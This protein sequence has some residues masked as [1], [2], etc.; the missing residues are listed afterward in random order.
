[1]R[2]LLLLLLLFATTTIHGQPDPAADRQPN[3][4]L[5]HP[6]TPLYPDTPL[7]QGAQHLTLHTPRNAIV[8]VH[9][10]KDNGLDDAGISS[11]FAHGPSDPDTPL[12]FDRFY[13]Q[14]VPVEQNTGL[15]SRTER[16]ERRD[17]PHVL[18]GAPFNVYEVMRDALG[19]G[20]VQDGRLV[21][22]Y[23]FHIPADLSTG[24]YEVRVCEGDVGLQAPLR[25]SL[26]VH[27]AVLPDPGRDT[28]GFTNWINVNTIVRFHGVSWFGEDFWPVLDRYAALCAEMRQNVIP[29]PIMDFFTLDDA[30]TPV[31]NREHMLRWIETFEAHGLHWIEL[32]HPAKRP[33][34]DNWSSPHLALRLTG[35]PTHTEAGRSTIAAMYRQ[36]D[37]LLREYAWSDRVLVHLADEPTDTNAA[38]YRG[39][40]EQVRAAMPGATIFEAT[41]SDELLGAVDAWCPQVHRWQRQRAFF[42]A[43]RNAGDDVWVYTCLEPGGP[44][45][46]RLLDMERT[47]IV[48]LHWLCAEFGLRGYLHW[49]LNHWIVDPFEQSVVL[50]PSD[51]SGNNWLPA[52]DTHVLYPGRDAGTGPYRSVRSEAHRMGMQDHALLTMLMQRDPAAAHAVIRSVVRAFDDYDASVPAYR[53][54]RRLLLEQLDADPAA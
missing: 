29:V 53:A 18:R 38:A 34:D 54:A 4:A 42:D 45:L 15:Q 14:A 46:N 10:V 24:T 16:Y 41:L 13:L 31:L 37:A 30:G 11:G 48:Y 21:M 26:V 32:M 28:L 25:L 52:G 49:A 36:L 43:R 19:P 5:F 35:E 8:S 2:H 44:W 6:L 40:A 1:M 33:E 9:L 27:D 3:A 51:R 22:A 50:H 17:N 7:S 20:V 12:R 47:R 23:R 39:L